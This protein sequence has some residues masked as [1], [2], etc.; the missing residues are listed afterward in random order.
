MCLSLLSDV[1]QW[2][3]C[4]FVIV[5]PYLCTTE[6]TLLWSSSF[7]FQMEENI[8]VSFTCYSVTRCDSLLQL[9]AVHMVIISL[10]N[11][12][13]GEKHPMN[14]LLYQHVRSSV[15]SCSICPRWERADALFRRLPD[16]SLRSESP[17]EACRERK[18]LKEHQPCVCNKLLPNIKKL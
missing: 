8:S 13:V 14:V 7:C 5:I 11:K 15:S 9:S 1:S 12:Y 3:N 2:Q 10:A 4:T 17:M 16:V 18:E 6:V